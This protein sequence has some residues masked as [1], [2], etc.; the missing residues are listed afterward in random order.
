MGRVVEKKETT[1][2]GSVS[3]GVKRFVFILS[4]GQYS[5][6]VKAICI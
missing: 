2:Q 6:F 1:K 5:L 3:W 4:G